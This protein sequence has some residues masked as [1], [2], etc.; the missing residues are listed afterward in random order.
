MG[1]TLVKIGDPNAE[2]P[3]PSVSWRLMSED[4]RFAALCSPW[5]QPPV[6]WVAAH[7]NGHV[8]V[9]LD[10]GLDTP[11]RGVLLRGVED[12]ITQA[13]DPALRVFCPPTQD[14]N[15]LRK[16]RGVKVADG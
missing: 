5:T 16:L 2:T 7:D 4:E 8:I 13:V 12:I 1:T 10:A 11:T 9:E 6:R 3:T 15:P 14:K